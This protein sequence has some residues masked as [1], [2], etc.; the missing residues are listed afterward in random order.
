MFEA[1]GGWRRT[2]H[3]EIGRGD[4][5]GAGRLVTL[6]ARYVALML[7]CIVVREHGVWVRGVPRIAKGAG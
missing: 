2:R 4:A 6:E 7:L 5:A 1:R 3:R